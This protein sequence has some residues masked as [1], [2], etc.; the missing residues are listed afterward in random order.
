MT[1]EVRPAAVDAEELRCQISEHYTEV[2]TPEGFHFHTGRPLSRM[3]G[4]RDGGWTSS[5]GTVDS[6]AGT[7]PV[8]DG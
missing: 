2:K 3:L 5:A 1:N 4:Y 7:E 8:L 6:F